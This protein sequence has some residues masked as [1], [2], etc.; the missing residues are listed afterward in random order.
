LI[1]TFVNSQGFLESSGA[2][3]L[4]PNFRGAE[5]TSVNRKTQ[6]VNDTSTMTEVLPVVMV[7]VASAVIA[8][9]VMLYIT[10]MRDRCS[11]K[12]FFDKRENRGETASHKQV[13][14]SLTRTGTSASSNMSERWVE[15][16]GQRDGALRPMMLPPFPP[17][18]D[19]M[20]DMEMTI[21]CVPP[22]Q[23][24]LSPRKSTMTSRLVD[25]NVWEDRIVPYD[26]SQAAGGGVWEQDAMTELTDENRVGDRTD[27][28]SLVQSP[29]NQERKIAAMS[30]SPIR[31]VSSRC[32]SF[33]GISEGTG[34]TP[35]LAGES[36]LKDAEAT[37]RKKIA[38]PRM[39]MEF[40][41]ETP[42]DEER[43]AVVGGYLCHGADVDVRESPSQQ[44]QLEHLIAS[45]PVTDPTGR[46]AVSPVHDMQAVPIHDYIRDIYFVAGITSS[47]DGVDFGI[48]LLDATCPVTHPSVVAV[49]AK[50]PLLGRIFT[51]D[52]VLHVNDT[53][54]AG[55][56]AVQVAKLL[57]CNSGDTQDD[58][59]GGTTKT[60]T[61]IK[62]TIMSS[63]VD[64]ASDADG[65]SDADGEA[66]LDLGF[67]DSAVEV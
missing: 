3:L 49:H 25:G 48:D 32:S 44:T 23:I 50:S 55:Q 58:V 37:P 26:Y 1:L 39:S 15:G 18:A 51:G 20:E 7:G 11:H 24:S 65:T 52:F 59:A 47:H 30:S 56:S 22:K 46:R 57:K 31:S 43:D 36:V 40:S 5:P 35:Q 21:A 62:L 34:S 38:V 66:S 67:A 28:E 4:Q 10:D 14:P 63:H 19:D 45:I 12:R 61:V 2:L 27:L 17:N 60:K 64:G 8:C 6:E 9:A 29:E 41:P 16:G 13:H 33:T 54:V 53:D 42:I